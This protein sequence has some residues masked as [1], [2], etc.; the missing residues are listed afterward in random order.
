M[1]IK[2][3]SSR[4][5]YFYLF[6]TQ[7]LSFV[8]NGQKKCQHKGQKYLGSY[9]FVLFGLLYLGTITMSYE[10][11]VT[12]PQSYKNVNI[13]PPVLRNIDKVDH[14]IKS[15]LLSC[16]LYNS[17]GGTIHPMSILAHHLPNLVLNTSFSYF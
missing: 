7:F 8:L 12:K 15:K 14:W 11:N 1:F 4:N 13:T 3:G 10:N 2:Y 6:H 5:L 16:F 9:K 17:L